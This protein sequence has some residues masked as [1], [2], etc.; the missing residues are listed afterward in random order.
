MG[1]PF[2]RDRPRVVSTA[3]DQGETLSKRVVAASRSAPVWVARVA[4][5]ARVWVAGSV[6]FVS[7]A[8]LAQSPSAPQRLSPVQAQS[9][10]DV[11][12]Q[13]SEPSRPL[14]V[15]AAASL[16]GAL[17]QALADWREAG[18]GPSLVTY[19]GTPALVRQIGQG[20]PADLFLSADAAWMDHLQSKG[21]LRPETRRDLL[22]NRLVLIA[23]SDREA[24]LPVAARTFAAP[25]EL[26][27][28]G[29]GALRAA[30]AN[31]PGSTRLAIAEVAS[32]PAGRYARGALEALGLWRAWSGRLAMTDNVRAALLLVARGE[33]ELGIVYA[34]DAQAERRVRVVGLLSESVHPPIR[35]PA[36]VLAAAAHSRASE[37]LDFLGGPVAMKRFVAAG[38]SQPPP[39]SAGAR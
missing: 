34:S 33:T 10:A 19:A 13:R 6:V 1:G 14:R 3:D 9:A 27:G 2:R 24:L 22:A 11:Q 5:L 26:G 21:A 17:D 28:A 36:A 12:S 18:G 35:Y 8:A 32:V 29:D 15:A 30:L 7:A 20:L 16:R 25:V 4:R 23:G 31:W 39:V 37:A 38:F